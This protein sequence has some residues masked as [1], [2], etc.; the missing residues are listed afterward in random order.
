MIELRV[1]RAISALKMVVEVGLV[2]GVTPQITP[3]GSAIEI[4]P[5]SLSSA[6]TPTVLSYLILFQMYSE[7]Y[8]FLMALS[9]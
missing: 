7:A 4:K 6:I 1:L 2:V 8:M 5:C 3:T 9:S